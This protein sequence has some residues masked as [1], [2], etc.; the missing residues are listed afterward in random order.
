MRVAYILS[1]P[2]SMKSKTVDALSVIRLLR[3]NRDRMAFFAFSVSMVLRRALIAF[4]TLLAVIAHSTLIR[5]A[6]GF[7]VG[8]LNGLPTSHFTNMSRR[9]NHPWAVSAFSLLVA[10][11]SQISGRQRMVLSVSFGL[12]AF[13]RSRFAMNP[14]SYPFSLLQIVLTEQR[15]SPVRTWY[16]PR[17]H[18]WRPGS[19]RLL[20]ECPRPSRHRS[21]L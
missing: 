8:L 17:G 7:A 12:N 18:P 14:F 15:F 6:S 5:N 9:Y 4:D 2:T 19:R 13:I 11:A 16:L 10:S 20:W 1:S 21:L 3:L